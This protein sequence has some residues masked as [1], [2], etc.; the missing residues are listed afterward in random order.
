VCVCVCVC[1]IQNVGYKIGVKASDK[2]YDVEIDGM[3][4]YIWRRNS[5]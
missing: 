2:W 3:Y 1:V 5:K 4:S